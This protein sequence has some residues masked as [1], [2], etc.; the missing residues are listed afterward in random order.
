MATVGNMAAMQYG[1]AVINTRQQMYNSMYKNY[2]NYRYNPFNT[3]DVDSVLENYV[4][5]GDKYVQQEYEKL[6]NSVFGKAEEDAADSTVSMKGSCGNVMNSAE[7]LTRFAESL[8]YGNEYDA[9]Q[10]QTVIENFVNDYNTFVENL[11]NSDSDL[12]LQ[13]GVIMVNT[14]KA[15]SGSLGRTGITVGSDN[16]LTFDKE[17]MSQI[18]AT[19]I[20]TTFGDYGFSEKA[21]QKAEQVNRLAGCSYLAGYNASSLQNYAYSI[22]ALFSTYA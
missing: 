1:M 7:A 9:E 2:N 21:Y 12:V 19:D 5:Y 10:A 13:K 20:K 22:G 18:S 3:T 6:Y 16:K 14:A 17:K 15:Y 4:K 11:G 8:R